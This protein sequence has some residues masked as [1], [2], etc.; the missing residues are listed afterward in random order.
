MI[1]EPVGVATA[2]I[3][4]VVAVVAIYNAKTS[5]DDQ[6]QERIRNAVSDLDITKSVY[7]RMDAVGT[8][9]ELGRGKGRSA[10]I[11][12]ILRE[13]VKAAE[14]QKGLGD[15]QLPPDVRYAIDYLEWRKAPKLNSFP[16]RP[17]L[18]ERI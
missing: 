18:P 1:I 4:A 8:L 15:P 11:I 17:G 16:A 9:I 5:R 3:A 2:G 13:F 12:P 7:V 14:A 6:V 10:R